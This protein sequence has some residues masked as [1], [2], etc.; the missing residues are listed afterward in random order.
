MATIDWKEAI[1]DTLIDT[2]VKQRGERPE[3]SFDPTDEL[4]VDL[5]KKFKGRETDEIIVFLQ[6]SMFAHM[7][8]TQKTKTPYYV[9]NLLSK[10]SLDYLDINR[11]ALRDH[12]TQNVEPIQF[13]NMVYGAI[14]DVELDYLDVM[15]GLWIKGTREFMWDLLSPNAFWLLF[16]EQ[17][18]RF[19]K[20]VSDSWEF[21]TTEYNKRQVSL[22]EARSLE[23]KKLGEKARWLSAQGSAKRAMKDAAVNWA[24]RMGFIHTVP[25]PFSKKLKVIPYS[26]L[27]LSLL[28]VNESDLMGRDRALFSWAADTVAT[29]AKD[30]GAP[31][32]AVAV[33]VLEHRPDPEPFEVHKMIPA[34][35]AYRKGEVEDC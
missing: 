21:L 9:K 35:A 27:D 32:H 22:L 3:G 30:D 7:V 14:Y 6:D 31:G 17:Y 19:D 10:A 5:L 1:P 4:I 23:R 34:V 20:T 33:R 11:D 15:G 12:Y 28:E 25:D 29:R 16:C 24:S 26:D 18:K 13:A 2:Y 8:K